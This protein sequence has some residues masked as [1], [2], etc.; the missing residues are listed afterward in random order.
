MWFKE[1]VDYN[2]NM[3]GGKTPAKAKSSRRG[4]KKKSTTIDA[5]TVEPIEES[6]DEATKSE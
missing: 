5:T 2:E 1:L 3:I 4:G 6:T